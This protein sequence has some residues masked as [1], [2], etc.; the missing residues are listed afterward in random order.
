MVLRRLPLVIRE[1]VVEHVAAQ[2][3]TADTK[4]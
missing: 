1:P 4:P 3:V 2:A